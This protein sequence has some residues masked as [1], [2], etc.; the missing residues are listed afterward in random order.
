MVLV[1]LENRQCSHA[2]VLG[3]LSRNTIDRL[4]VVTTGM[5]AD[6]GYPRGLL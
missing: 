2:Q 4:D 1:V 3:H 6:G 5:N